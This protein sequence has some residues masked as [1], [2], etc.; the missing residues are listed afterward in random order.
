MQT[1]PETILRISPCGYIYSK[2]PRQR[3]VTQNLIPCLLF[4]DITE[5]QKLKND[6]PEGNRLSSDVWETILNIR[7]TNKPH[8]WVFN[9][10]SSKIITNQLMTFSKVSRPGVPR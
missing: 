1:Q 5:K 2:I 9:K 8:Y 6:T 10:Y 3:G 7:L 4:M